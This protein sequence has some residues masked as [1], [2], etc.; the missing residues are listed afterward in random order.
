[1]LLPWQTRVSDLL[2]LVWLKIV[3]TVEAMH[4]LLTTAENEGW[5][6]TMYASLCRLCELFGHA[7]RSDAIVAYLHSALLCASA[8]G[9]D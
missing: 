4:G 5:H 8:L 1:M 3:T 7:L 2:E 9:L 6:T